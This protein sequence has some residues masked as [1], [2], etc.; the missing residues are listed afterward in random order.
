M[1]EMITTKERLSRNPCR[2]S[3]N[4]L[5]DLKMAGHIKVKQMKMHLLVIDPQNDFTSPKKGSLYVLGG[6]V[7]MDKLAKMTERLAGKLADIHVTLDSHHPFDIAHPT[8]WRDSKGRAPDPFTLISAADVRAKKWMPTLISFYDPLLSYL[9]KLEKSGKY[10]HTIW[11]KHC[12]I[13]TEGHNVWPNLM[14]SFDKWTDRG[15]VIDYLGNGL[16]IRRY[17]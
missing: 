17:V 2:S 6:D 13:G 9:E 1:V 16:R 11:P 10:V 5:S 12:L 4:D 3:G 15:G 14:N 7:A 8:M